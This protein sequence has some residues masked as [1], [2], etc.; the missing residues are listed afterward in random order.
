MY[1][2]LRLVLSDSREEVEA[3][4]GEDVDGGDAAEVAPVVAVRGGTQG[5]V[6]VEDVLPREETRTVG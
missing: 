2:P 5:G 3:V 1:E 4:V 6:V